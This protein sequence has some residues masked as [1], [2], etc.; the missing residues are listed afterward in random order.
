MSTGDTSIDGWRERHN[1]TAQMIG[2]SLAYGGIGGSFAT[3]KMSEPVAAGLLTAGQNTIA[4]SFNVSNNV[5]MG[6]RVIGMDVL[7]SA[8]TR[9]IP[10]AG[11]AHTDP[12]S[13]TGPGT[14]L[15][16]I[17]AG[18]ALWATAAL[19][20]TL[21]GPATPRRPSSPNAATATP[22]TALISNT[23][24]TQTTPSSNAR[25]FKASAKLK[26]SRSRAI[27]AACR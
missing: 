14:A 19:K 4:F 8:G 13:W 10:A 26:A 2:K 24:A 20:A 9:L 7:D 16:D 25:N 5:S 12:A 17:N 18:K 15:A 27:S 1:T 6:Y 3:L 22:K 21:I 11:F 23:L